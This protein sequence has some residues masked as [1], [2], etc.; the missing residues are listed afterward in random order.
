MTK[1]SKPYS[2]T[3]KGDRNE[4]IEA[5]DTSY[6][7]ERFIDIF[8]SI[9]SYDFGEDLSDM[10][11]GFIEESLYWHGGIGI[12]DTATFGRV[13]LPASPKTTSIYGK[14]ITWQPSFTEG[15]QYSPEL[16]KE[17]D[18]PAL[19]FRVPLAKKIEPYLQVMK[20]SLQVL[21]VNVFALS[22]PVGLSGASNGLKM[23]GLLL[24]NDLANGSKIIP[25]INKDALGIEVIDL[26][27]TDYTQALI[28]VMR[29]M[30]D[31][32]L[33]IGG[34]KNQGTE[35]A[36]GITSEETLSVTQ[37]LNLIIMQGL[38]V[39]EQWIEK[40]N[41]YFGTSYTVT[42]NECLLMEMEEVEEEPEEEDTEGDD[43]QSDSDE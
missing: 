18:S 42:L 38:K 30:Y 2:F 12:K 11:E 14:P 29:A 33:T 35:K 19:Y 15:T 43:E 17:S 1:P 8:K 21:S 36:S 39:R 23:D 10:P 13:C 34:I 32:I 25:V 4:M 5:I 7:D 9:Y 40:V 16:M 41:A 31:E 28:G 22:Q 20:E 6:M 3:T 24:R 27:A 37:A 26:K